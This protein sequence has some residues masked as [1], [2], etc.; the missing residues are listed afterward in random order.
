MVI[1]TTEFAKWMTFLWAKRTIVFLR[2]PRKLLTFFVVKV[3][4]ET[5]IQFPTVTTS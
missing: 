1:R 5:L 2:L 3:A 4:M